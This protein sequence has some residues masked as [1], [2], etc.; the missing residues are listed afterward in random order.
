MMR[1]TESLA[2]VLLLA[3]VAAACST[4]TTTSA[5]ITPMTATGAPA[6]TTAP[7]ALENSVGQIAFAS[8]RDGNG[9]VYV[10][11]VD[12]SNQTRL[13]NNPADD[14]DLA[15]SADGTKI[16]FTSG[17]GW[18]LRGVCDGRRRIEPD[19]AHQQPRVRCVPGVVGGGDQESPSP[20]AGMATSR[21]M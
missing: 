5:P 8:N 3:L 13:T 11:D 10:M 15:W 7:T 12:G 2:A 18:Q 20:R 1:R 9:E 16:A 19:P 17:P 21:C 6:A 14:G 4:P